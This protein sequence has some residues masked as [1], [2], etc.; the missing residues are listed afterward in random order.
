[1]VHYNIVRSDS[2]WWD[3]ALTLVN[4][5]TLYDN[6][7]NIVASA[8]LSIFPAERR[9]IPIIVRDREGNAKGVHFDGRVYWASTIAEHLDHWH[10]RGI[11]TLNQRDCLGD[12]VSCLLYKELAW[13]LAY[14]WPNIYMPHV[15]QERLQS[16]N[17]GSFLDQFPSD[18]YVIELIADS[19]TVE[20]EAMTSLNSFTLEVEGFDWENLNEAIEDLFN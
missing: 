3:D 14:F 15:S 17:L 11:I 12:I 10:L 5:N 20:T 19:E 6:M 1:M 2:F 13:D 8:D 18:P 7:G 4:D 9:Y 16:S